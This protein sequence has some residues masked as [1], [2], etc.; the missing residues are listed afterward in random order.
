MLVLVRVTR[1]CVNRRVARHVIHVRTLAGVM[2]RF[3][4]RNRFCGTRKSGRD[5]EEQCEEPDGQRMTHVVNLLASRRQSHSVRA[6][7]SD[8]SFGPHG[9]G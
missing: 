5:S 6:A 1:L 9:V 4:M 7:A 3:T 8:V 2:M